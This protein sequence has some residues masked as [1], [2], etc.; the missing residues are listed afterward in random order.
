MKLK[1]FADIVNFRMK[2]STAAPRKLRK[3]IKQI[4]RKVA[5]KMS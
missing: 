2:G 4:A 3:Y 1:N 5:F